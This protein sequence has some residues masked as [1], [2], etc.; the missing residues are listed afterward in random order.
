MAIMRIILL[1]SVNW[2]LDTTIILISYHKQDYSLTEYTLLKLIKLERTSSIGYYPNAKSMWVSVVFLK[3]MIMRKSGP[4]EEHWTVLQVDLFYLIMWLSH[5]SK[6]WTWPDGPTWTGPLG[7][8][9]STLNRNKR[10][11]KHRL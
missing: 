9:G 7:W 11:K 1:C 3:V 8:F 5:R 2:N 6:N 10:R 4:D